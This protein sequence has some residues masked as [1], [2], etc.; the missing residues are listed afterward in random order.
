MSIIKSGLIVVGCA[1]GLGS[2]LA[3][4]GEQSVGVGAPAEP[5]CL[6]RPLLLA[7]GSVDAAA[8]V[9]GAVQRERSEPAVHRLAGE[10]G[11]PTRGVGAIPMG[12]SRTPEPRP[13]RTPAR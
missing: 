5:T 3:L 10:D 1:L 2:V 4:A 8:G 11:R 6:E 7:S 13:T 12:A 9:P